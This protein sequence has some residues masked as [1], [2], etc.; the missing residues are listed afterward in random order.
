[1]IQGSSLWIPQNVPQWQAIL[2]RADEIYY[3]G[4]AGGGKSDLAIG[5]AITAHQRSLI[6]RRE[7]TQL[8][9]IIERSREIIGDFGRLN[10]LLG[11]WHLNDGKIIE[12]SGCKLEKDKSKFQGRPHDLIAFDEAPEFLQSQV[13]FII[14]WLRTENVNQRTRIIYTG[15]PPLS[16]EGEWILDKFAPWVDDGFENPAQ[17]GELRFYVMLDGKETWVESGEPVI[18]KG[19]TIHPRSRTFIPSSV[20]DNPYYVETDYKARLQALPE[21][22]RSLLLDSNFRAI[23]QD[24][25]YQVIPTLWIELAQKRWREQQRPNTPM[26]RLGVDVAR[27]GDDKTVLCKRYDNWIAPL[28]KHE[29]KNTPDGPS[30]AALTTKAISENPSTQINID[31]I[32]WGS[33]AYD[34]LASQRLSVRGI[35]FAE[36]TKARDKSRLL[37][38][39]NKRAEYYWRAREALD[40]INGDNLAIPDDRELKADLTAPRYTVTTRGVVV[41]SKEDIKKRLGRSTDC[42]DAFVLSLESQGIFIG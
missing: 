4:S 38:M 18:H 7:S 10:E 8:R 30:V 6:L 23:K 3:G 25:P 21:P 35:N 1:M 20:D 14:G 9:A 15:N 12:L 33:S 22:L 5:L 31:I 40:P 39:A 26:S 32:G 29:G 24:N 42:G 17:P 2:T 19:E 13:E 34:I 28:E 11:V 16:I 37:A 41:E 36:G 27:G